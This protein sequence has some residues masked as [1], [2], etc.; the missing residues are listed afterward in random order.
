M[1]TVNMVDIT[2][3]HNTTATHEEIVD[4]IR[5]LLS[6]GLAAARAT[7]E[8]GEGDLIKARLAVDIDNFQPNPSLSDLLR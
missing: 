6:C 3:T 8:R 2:V 1:S 5:Y 4:V 7:L